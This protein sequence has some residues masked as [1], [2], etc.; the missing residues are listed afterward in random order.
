MMVTDR[1]VHFWTEVTACATDM[2]CDSLG[3]V[4]ILIIREVE[5]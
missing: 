2:A 5:P 4:F 3:L 1:N